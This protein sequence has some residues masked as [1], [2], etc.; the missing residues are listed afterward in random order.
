MTFMRTSG[1]RGNDAR[2][3]TGPGLMRVLEANEVISKSWE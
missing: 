3:G 1:L 2:E